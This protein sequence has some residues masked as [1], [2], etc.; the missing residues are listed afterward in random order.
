MKYNYYSFLVRVFH[1]YHLAAEYLVSV[2]RST[3]LN[4]MAKEMSTDDYADFRANHLQTPEAEKEHFGP[5]AKRLGEAICGEEFSMHLHLW[6][7]G[8]M[9]ESDDVTVSQQEPDSSGQPIMTQKQVEHPGIKVWLLKATV[10]R[11][12]GFIHAMV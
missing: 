7:R 6:R 12:T 10:K 5:I 9:I 11:P 2:P 1:N 4:D 3:L 8:H